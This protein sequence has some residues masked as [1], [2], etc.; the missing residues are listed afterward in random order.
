MSRRHARL[1]AFLRSNH[2]LEYGAETLA[3]AP[4]Y[5]RRYLKRAQM[6]PRRRRKA[7]RARIRA[8]RRAHS[9][10]SPRKAGS[11]SE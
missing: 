5:A 1:R 2:Y 8:A 7:E 4:D 11:P 6:S 9:L 10:Q 3:L